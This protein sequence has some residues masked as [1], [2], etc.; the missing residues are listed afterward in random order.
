MADILILDNS[1]IAS[2]IV[3]YWFPD[4]KVEFKSLKSF[5]VE[6]ILPFITHYKTR[7]PESFIICFTNDPTVEVAAQET[8]IDVCFKP[9]FDVDKFQNQLRTLIQ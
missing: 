8:E 7:Y 5:L 2:M 4:K 9:L 3:Q 6:D 1:P